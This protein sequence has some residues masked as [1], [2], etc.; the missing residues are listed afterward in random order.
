MSFILFGNGDDKSSSSSHHRLH[1]L[2]ASSHVTL[3]VRMCAYICACSCPL[4]IAST[5]D[6]KYV[7]PFFLQTNIWL[8]WFL[9]CKPHQASMVESLVSGIL[10]PIT[11]TCWSRTVASR[12]RGWWYIR[13]V[14]HITLS[15][16]R[17]SRVR[18]GSTTG[19]IRQPLA[20]FCAII[21]AS[22]P[23]LFTHAHTH[24]PPSL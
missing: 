20:L 14:S 12:R 3:R 17:G 4:K 24:A 9:L 16:N 22:S 18:G 8:I 11:R 13:V 5:T 21:V 15:R 1:H 2:P 10:W 7:F 23:F 6:V 19:K